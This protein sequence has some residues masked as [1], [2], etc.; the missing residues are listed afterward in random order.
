M[1]TASRT[2][3]PACIRSVGTRCE[4]CVSYAATT[5]KTPTYSFPSA[6]ER[7]TLSLGHLG[8][9]ASW[10]RQARDDFRFPLD[11]LGVRAGFSFGQYLLDNLDG[12]LDLLIRHRLDR[13]AVLDL[14]FTRHQH[15]ADLAP[16][17]WVGV[18]VLVWGSQHVSGP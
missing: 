10:R 4:R 16:L 18:R 15:S 14:H 9:A 7:L 12:P 17:R 5:P 1:C 2:G 8:A 6:V 13:I 11:Q 3:L